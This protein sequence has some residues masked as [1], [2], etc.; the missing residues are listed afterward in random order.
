MRQESQALREKFNISRWAIKYPWFTFGF[1]IAIA[2]AGILAF[3]T[4]KYALFP[5]IT[6]PVVIVN[7]TAD[8][9]NT[10][11]TES[12]ITKPIE[13]AVKTLDN[14]DDI[15]SYTYQGNSAVIVSFNVG[16]SLD[17]SSK[18]VK[19]VIE[20]LTLPKSANFQVI[21]LNL[22]ES[23]A[24]TYIIEGK[25]QKITDLITQ[26][27]KKI[28]PELEKISGVLKVDLLGDTSKLDPVELLDDKKAKSILSSGVT[29]VRFNGNE[30]LAIQIIKRADANTIDLVN[31]ISKKVIQ[32]NNDY[33]NLKLNL[34]SS[35]SD[36]IKES[37]QATLED[38]FLAIALSVLVIY[39]FL[40]S[41][42][43]VLISAITIPTSL[44]ATFIFMASFGFN[45]E[46]I[47]LLALALV[48]GII[49]DDAIVDVEN[50]SR[51]LEQGENPKEAAILATD[52]IGLTVTAA[53]LTIVAVFLPVA[54]MKGTIGQ[55]FKPFGLTV[56]VAVIASLLAARTLS[57]LLAMYWLKPTKNKQ[58]SSLWTYFIDRYKKLLTWS[59]QH[60]TI[61]L[62]IAVITFAIGVGLIP[63]VPKGFIPNLDRGEF[64]VRYTAPLPT[65]S[66]PSE[67]SPSPENNNISAPTSSAKNPKNDLNKAI[68]D[69]PLAPDINDFNPM[70]E[71]IDIS[72]QLQI[73]VSKNPHVES[74]LT[75]TGTKN[76]EINKGTLYVK[77]KSDRRLHTREIQEQIR[78]QL[79]KIK[80]VNTSIEDIQFVDTGGEKPLQLALIGDDLNS[81]TNTAQLIKE[82]VQKIPGFVD[83][84]ATGSGN[85]N[86][87]IEEIQH[88]NGQRVAYISA[89]LTKDLTIGAATDQIVAEAQKTL[90]SDIK[91]NL[92]GDSKRATEILS[93]FGI[94]LI[95][96]VGCIFLLLVFLFRSWLDPLVIVFSLPLSLVGAM[97]ALLITNSEFGMISVIGIILLMGLVNKNAILMVDYINQLRY[98]G[99]S[100]TEAILTASPVRLRPILMTTAATILGMIP[101]ALGLGAGAELRQPM[102]VT[103]VGGLVT[104]TLL[105][106]IVVP[107]FYALLD[108]IQIGKKNNQ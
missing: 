102:A 57:P 83:V 70:N 47:T 75:I 13:N 89:N 68:F 38:L 52:E 74:V 101:I 91:L 30:A 49:V 17:D 78:E 5:D 43:A 45:L 80:D 62:A 56:S 15:K 85:I 35:Q 36:F 28:I 90:P 4:L 3:S 67:T 51:H 27:K 54:L 41:W 20:Q 26:T 61:V 105:S 94:T 18:K 29:S 8:I 10:L 31:T 87:K 50:I 48:I 96:S 92:G 58:Q 25:N 22:N 39:P 72:Q 69:D 107:V 11:D 77:L 2:V 81:L 66:P 98:Q 23:A 1:W 93:S 59:L 60:R 40:H 88:F 37:T 6:F 32:I 42:K 21:K 44:L 106:L 34:A 104:S 7:T 19:T 24:V 100:R 99:M 65:L 95:S 16:T 12:K 86:G 33:P 73:A 82:K 53:T 97:L 103:I 79:P 71:Y 55:F 108:D 63:F 76:G 64:Y 14:L 46:T 84:T 9:N